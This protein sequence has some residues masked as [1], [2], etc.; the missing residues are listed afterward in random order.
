MR[1]RIAILSNLGRPVSHALLGAFLVVALVACGEVPPGIPLF[2]PN[3][4]AFGMHQEVGPAGGL[5]VLEGN[6]RYFTDAGGRRAVY[7]TGSHTWNNFQDWGRT[8]PPSPFDYTAYLDFLEHHGHNFIR[9][10]VWEQAAWFPGTEEKVVIAPLPYLRTGPTRALDGGLRFDLTQFNPGYFR[11]LRERVEA[12]RARGIYV[13]VMLF[14]GWSIELKGKKSGN[15]WRGHP[16]NREN[17]VSGIDGDMDGDGEGKEVHTLLNPAVTSLQKTY[18]RKITETLGDLDNV[19]WEISNESHPGAVEWQYEMIRTIKDLESSTGKPH[20]VGMTSMWPHGKEGNASLF[21][22]P[23]DWIS[24]HRNATEPYGDNPPASTGRKIILSDTDHIWGIGGDAR[25]VWMSFLRGLNPI[26]MDP[27]EM[28]MRDNYPLWPSSEVNGASTSSPAPEWES[29][30]KAMGYARALAD[31]I[32][33][34]S[35][36]PMG[37]LASTGYCL[38]AP[39]KEY[40]VYLPSQDGR[41][42]HLIGSILKGLAGEHVE[43]DLSP[44]QG[45]LDVEWIDVERG[46]IFP[47]DPVRGGQRLGFHAPF[48]GDAVLHVKA[49]EGT[50]KRP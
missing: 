25:W 37:E 26:F 44:T 42:R 50:S 6:P 3:G 27:Y 49:R 15:P 20:P 12:A 4:P 47:G 28:A 41:L 18:L 32:E 48:A 10:Y 29:I 31:R 24:P 46:Q 34:A 19:L 35:M 2:P 36:R 21:E 23:A 17:N 7:L 45:T 9:L 40:L 43:V 38:A 8:D 33:L 5:S 11:R 16:F 30:R 13:S 14:D 39:G 1:S 22:S